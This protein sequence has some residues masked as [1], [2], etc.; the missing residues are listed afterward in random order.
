MPYEKET[1]LQLHDGQCQFKAPFM[2]YADLYKILKP[3]DKHYRGKM[4]KV[5]KERKGKTSYTKR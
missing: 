4:N 2:L 1:W 3:V 5:K